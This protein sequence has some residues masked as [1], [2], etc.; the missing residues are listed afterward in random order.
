M[1]LT[2]TEQTILQAVVDRIIP[3]DDYPGAWEAGVGDYIARQLEGDLRSMLRMV[4]DG[5]T[6]LDAEAV[7]QYGHSFIDL[8]AEQQDGLLR[9][10]EAG[11][12]K[13]SWPVSPARCFAQWVHLTGEGYYSDPGNGGNRNGVAWE[14]IGFKERYDPAEG[15]RL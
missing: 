5:L 14:M 9:H 13:T 12:V 4:R 10:V 8:D 2:E 11:N 6:A 3:P 1:P 15:G 7:A